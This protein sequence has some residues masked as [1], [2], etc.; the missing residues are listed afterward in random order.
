M[1]VN[2]MAASLRCSVWAFMMSATQRSELRHGAPDL[3]QQRPRAMPLAPAFDVRPVELVALHADDA[4]HIV[5]ILCASPPQLPNDHVLGC[6]EKHLPITHHH[7][8]ATPEPL[9]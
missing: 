3:L 6:R 5:T 9:P 8:L 1:S 2:M 7:P 4:A